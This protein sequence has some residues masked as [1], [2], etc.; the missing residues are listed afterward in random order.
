MT[1]NLKWKKYRLLRSS[2]PNEMTFGWLPHSHDIG[3]F[4]HLIYFKTIFDI[5]S[6]F[7]ILSKFHN[8]YELYY[9]WS[10]YI[11][12]GLPSM[13]A[14]QNTMN[15]IYSAT[16]RS[17]QPYHVSWYCCTLALLLKVLPSHHCPKQK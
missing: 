1:Y 7:S 14:N 12:V 11:D 9:T 2:F 15:C 16:T 8:N 5:S 13:H 17:E 4:L 6:L 3:T 10:L